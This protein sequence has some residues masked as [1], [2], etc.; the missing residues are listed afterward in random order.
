M[1]RVII[2]GAGFAGLS[3]S[4]TLAEKGIPSHLVSLQ[5][6]ERSQ[7]VLAEGGI[8]GA[9]NTMGEDDNTENHFNDTGFRHDSQLYADRCSAGICGE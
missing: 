3:A 1:N 5:P 8:N 6:S 9:L 4:I 2:I 7:S